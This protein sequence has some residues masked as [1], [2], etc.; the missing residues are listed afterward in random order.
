MNNY[1]NLQQTKQQSFR[2]YNPSHLL[3]ET[4]P[5]IIYMYETLFYKLTDG[6]VRPEFF[7]VTL[8]VVRFKPLMSS[9]YCL[10]STSYLPGLFDIFNLLHIWQNCKCFGDFTP[11][12][13]NLNPSLAFNP[14]HICLKFLEFCP[15]MPLIYVSF[16]FPFCSFYYAFKNRFDAEN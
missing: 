12:R 5:S 13:K 14:E 9:Q 6:Q 4:F 16:E 2:R 7:K 11:T 3:K 1:A 10:I 8:T 15:L